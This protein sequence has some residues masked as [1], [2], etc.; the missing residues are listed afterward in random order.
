MQ[1]NTNL[2]VLK[3]KARHA[4]NSS[5]EFY[6]ATIIVWTSASFISTAKAV[7]V[8]TV[9]TSIITSTST[10]TTTSL[11]PVFTTIY[12]ASYKNNVNNLN[13]SISLATIQ[14]SV[15]WI[16]S[17][18]SNFLY[19]INN[20]YINHFY[21]DN[22]NY[23]N[24]NNNNNTTLINE[25]GEIFPVFNDSNEFFDENDNTVDILMDNHTPHAITTTTTRK[26]LNNY[27]ALLAVLLVIFTAAGNILVCLAI[28][29]ERRLQNVTNYFLMSLAITDLMVAILVMPL[30]ILTLVKGK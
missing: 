19:D 12:N 3:R 6:T 9:A 26:S 20:N 22:K 7:V 5:Q 18:S 21:S 28:T 15:D 23:I 11:S 1:Y 24:N 25:T 29:W 2:A 8:A 4:L 17:T 30:G 14:S 10:A 16:L 27:W 13:S